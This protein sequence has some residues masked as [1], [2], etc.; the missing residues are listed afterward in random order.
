MKNEKAAPSG[1]RRCSR[2]NQTKALHD[3]VRNRS[4]R[5]GYGYHCKPCHNRVSRENRERHHGT[6]RNYL[7]KHR[8]G[9][10]SEIF[11]ALVELQDG[12]CGIC[13][14]TTP[15]HLDHDHTTGQP[16]GV[17]CF[18]CNGALGQFR[19][20]VER[21]SSA[22]TYLERTAEFENSQD[23]KMLMLCVV[24]RVWLPPD[25]FA[26]DGRCRRGRVSWC[27]SC[28]AERGRA[29][30]APYRTSPRR[31]HLLTKYGVDVFEVE[32]LVADQR[33][34]C[35]ICGTE[36]PEHVDHD[37]R[38]GTIRGVL[39]AA[40]NAG[41]GQLG[42]DPTIVRKAI[43]YLRERSPGSGTVREPATSYILSVA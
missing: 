6:S 10:S 2:C 4:D 19:D 13:A 40:C 5:S 39:C 35:P 25:R 8:Y 7:L 3:F 23:S 31:F 9:A 38:T 18:K 33:G 29:A 1:T 32:E 43:D 16:R 34:L 37:H 11:D 27:V 14:R 15:G 21:L 26:A 42:D 22:A 28:G 24:C 17:L 41:L 12:T 36:S 30:I 20:D